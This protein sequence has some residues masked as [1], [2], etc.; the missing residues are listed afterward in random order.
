MEEN[1]P[2]L[3]E[4]NIPEIE[5]MVSVCAGLVTID[6][7]SEIIRLVHYTAQEYFERAQRQWFPNAQTNITQIC[8]TYLSFNEFE[9][10]ICQNYKQF[11]QRLPLNKLYNY[12]AHNWGHHAREA[13]TSCQVIEFLQK[14]AQVE[15]SSEVLVGIT[16]HP[17]SV[18]Y[19]QKILKQMT[20]LHLAAYFGVYDA[21]RDLVN[22]YN[23]DLKDC[24]GRTPLSWATQNGHLKVVQL[25]LDKGADVNVANSNR[26]TPLHGAS[27][28]GRVE[29]VQLLLEHDADVEAKDS[30]NRTPLLYAA[31]SGNRATVELLV[32]IDR[33]N[34][35]SK[36]YYNLIGLSI[37]ARMGHRDIVALLLTKSRSLDAKDTF[38]R[39]P[40]WWAR[41]TGHSSTADLLLKNYKENGI[42][43]LE[44]DLPPTLIMVSSDKQMKFCDVCVLDISNKDTYYHCLVCNNGNFDIC[45][46]CFAMEARCLDQCHILVRE[47]NG[48]SAW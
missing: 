22:I 20:G 38:G 47:I 26:E 29:I 28:S 21:V 41:K 27:A 37:A 30:V 5:D 32:T 4:D 8:V 40:L 18:E 6:E 48:K 14:Q 33:V 34:V 42:N 16:L 17:N 43:T 45:E 2:E 9:S 7:Q 44:G 39:S 3:D 25:L 23:P 13:S 36:D 15:A 10:G 12:A 19:S 11:K 24:Y 31:K 1:E 35:D 46:E